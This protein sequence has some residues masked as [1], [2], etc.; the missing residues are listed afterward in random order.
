MGTAGG[1]H[2]A[3]WIGRGPGGFNIMRC[4]NCG[5]KTKFRGCSSRERR[6]LGLCFN[7]FEAYKEEKE[8]DWWGRLLKPCSNIEAIEL[9]SAQEYDG[10]VD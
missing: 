8:W 2:K 4:K 7:C 9:T 10:F 3:K 5:N 6:L 1:F